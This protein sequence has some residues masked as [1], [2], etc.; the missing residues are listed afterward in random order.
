[1]TNRG[2]GIGAIAIRLSV[3]LSQRNAGRIRALV[4]RITRDVDRDPPIWEET[5]TSL[6]VRDVSVR[7]ADATWDL[8][9][10]IRE[11][12]IALD[13]PVRI[14]CHA[15]AEGAAHQDTVL[16][17]ANWLV[18]RGRVGSVALSW[19]LTHALA[20]PLWDQVEVV[21][22]VV[23]YPAEGKGE[24]GARAIEYE[25]FTAPRRYVAST[26][27]ASTDAEGFLEVDPSN[28]VTKLVGEL[29]RERRALILGD[30]WI[31]KTWI[32]E[33]LAKQLRARSHFVW[34]ISFEHDRATEVPVDE[35]ERWKRSSEAGYLI[36]DALDEGFYRNRAAVPDR[37][38]RLSE[39]GA[40]ASRLHV[41]A[42]SRPSHLKASIEALG[43]PE[44]GT[45]GMTWYVLP[46]DAEA[47]AEALATGM[48]PE[49]G[50][51]KIELVRSHVRRLANADLVRDFYVL[52]R[53]GDETADVSLVQL[54]DAV[55]DE[56]C[57]PTRGGT[58]IVEPSADR[59]DAA[60]RIAAVLQFSGAET[61]DLDGLA[62][63]SRPDG[64]PVKLRDVFPDRGRVLERA[65]RELARSALFEQTEHHGYRFRQHFAKERL[66]AYALS[67]ARL[68]LVRRL[69][70]GPRGHVALAHR[71]VVDKLV[72]V[73]AGTGSRALALKALSDESARPL[74]GQE[75]IALF[76]QILRTVAS[77]GA[78]IWNLRHGD[79]L[80]A[81]AHP[82]VAERAMNCIVDATEPVGRRMIA[83]DIASVNA[84]APGWEDIA[85]ATLSV[86]LDPAQPVTLREDCVRFLCYRNTPSAEKL[87]PQLEQ[88]L[89][90][91]T[92]E[93]ADLR[94]V[95]LSDALKRGAPV[96]E[97]ARRAPAS[98]P[99]LVDARAVLFHALIER[100][101]DDDA[102]VILDQHLGLRSAELHAHVLSELLEPAF[103]RFMKASW[104]SGDADM[105]RIR[106]ALDRNDYRTIDADAAVRR[107]TDDDTAKRRQLFLACVEAHPYL[108]RLKPAEDAQWLAEVAEA[109]PSPHEHLLIE[110]F[111]LAQ[112]ATMNAATRE[113]MET[114][115]R[116]HHAKFFAEQEAAMNAHRGAKETL[117]QERAA[118]QR[119]RREP[120]RFVDE[121]VQ[122]IF[123]DESLPSL[124]Q[125]QN[126]GW[127]L[128]DREHFRPTNVVGSVTWLSPE[129]RREVMRRLVAAL[130]DASPTVIAIS[131][132]SY[133]SAIVH[134][135]SAF[136]AA[137]LGSD[138]G[139]WLSAP[140]VSKW[141]RSL[142][143]AH[144]Q[145]SA[146]VVAACFRVAPRETQDALLEAVR[147][148][149]ANEAFVNHV[150]DFPDGAV[151]DPVFVPRVLEIA[152]SA[153][154]TA[155]AA[156]A[157]V[158][159]LA[160]RIGK[161]LRD[162]L[163]RCAWPSASQRMVAATRSYLRDGEGIGAVFSDLP[164]ISETGLAFLDPLF[165]RWH[166]WSVDI[167]GWSSTALA[168]LGQW[169]LERF[170]RVSDPRTGCSTGMQVVT[171]WNRC[172]ELRDDVIWKLIER[173]DKAAAAA[174][175]QFTASDPVIGEWSERARSAREIDEILG[176]AEGEPE[177]LA[178]AE[179][180]KMLESNAV[181]ALRT[182]DDLFHVL[183]ELLDEIK[184][185]TPRYAELIWREP[186]HAD[187][188]EPTTPAGKRTK[189][190]NERRL[191]Q[192][193]Q[194]RL[195][196]LL[197]HRF[198]SEVSL[199]P[200]VSE[201]YRDRPDLLLHLRA[202]SV[203]IEVKWSHDGRWL[204]D[205]E[206]LAQNYVVEQPP[207]A[208]GIYVVGFTGRGPRNDLAAVERELCAR[209]RELELTRVGVKLGVVVVPVLR[210][211]APTRTNIGGGSITS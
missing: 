127:V 124:Q 104:G 19:P 182:A 63:A 95:I 120:R 161:R 18:T 191:R 65:A 176:A 1:M 145:D 150:C 12:I 73:A 87:R 112:D 117:Q 4:D 121:V 142:L 165:R 192:Y 17:L 11:D 83:C 35:W 42:F 76:E 151:D 30:P 148:E 126:F 158:H 13:P 67:D 14:A 166:D 133:S 139:A 131:R 93:T 59:R 82:R 86:A 149:A 132:G 178:P 186:G 62:T 128:F 137:V 109:A 189:E 66:A 207:R 199:A 16:E 114:W 134:E 47:A 205:L 152:A 2:Q 97:I 143:F 48:D 41:L 103:D 56:L 90:E 22:N 129:R 27:D 195:K 169:L 3:G 68:G 101:S 8:A 171:R 115:L 36:I 200:E 6:I 5:G 172:I 46:L 49:L 25:R 107:I 179:V 77:P 84:S 130:T 55:I 160:A 89:D 147:R 175:E 153:E 190:Q 118:A 105:A 9:R 135:A 110:V 69:T 180:A 102:R 40:A 198:G 202:E 122:E 106:R 167:S 108:V 187:D 52:R 85:R 204:T 116:T 138:D 99:N 100:M 81:L 181:S 28:A 80:T 91:L 34:T 154:S 119:T 88:L 26:R 24:P 111:R 197:S 123:D 183:M 33:Q 61:I 74:V 98:E 146:A 162:P 206:K 174:I 163:T 203:A 173:N 96:L 92:E 78:R 50:R 31:G 53:L 60:A 15:D 159:S 141:L 193:L 45:A 58:P 209:A 79:A 94:A 188:A 21:A 140:V 156:Q 54:E 177:R 64:S 211:P 155:S 57:T 23:Q 184:A 51:R 201:G 10:R 39:V 136:R 168:E 185:D 75:A 164:A 144:D 43:W 7:V 113:Q 194:M 210:Q 170:P 29:T 38:R 37:L 70:T 196:D 44:Q 20:R 32:A 125:V 208:H 71:P 157:I 72:A